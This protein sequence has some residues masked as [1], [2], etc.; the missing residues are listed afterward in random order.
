MMSAIIVIV[1]IVI[2]TSLAFFPLYKTRKM[3]IRN[4][5]KRSILHNNLDNIDDVAVGEW[6]WNWFHS[7]EPAFN[8]TWEEFKSV[9][10]SAAIFYKLHK[11]KQKETLEAQEVESEV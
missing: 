5:E 6:C 11:D 10:Y 7:D 3:L 9:M 1:A 8:P 2:I 4:Y